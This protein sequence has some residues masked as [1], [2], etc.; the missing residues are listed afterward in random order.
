MAYLEMRSWTGNDSLTLGDKGYDISF[1][2]TNFHTEEML[3]HKLVDF[4]IQFMEE[5]DKE[6]SEMKL[7]LNARAR[8]VA[9]SFLTPV[10][11][12]L[13]L[14]GGIELMLCSSIKRGVWVYGQAM[15]WCTVQIDVYRLG[16]ALVTLP[17]PLFLL[18]GSLDSNW[19]WLTCSSS[20]YMIHRR[21][22]RPHSSDPSNCSP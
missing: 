4:I 11:C 8:F 6:I 14:N 9:E 10:R 22:P 13:T 16:K 15:A 21:E 3:K 20:R 18:N 5:V 12:L 19:L 7:F 1:L 17:V 2:I